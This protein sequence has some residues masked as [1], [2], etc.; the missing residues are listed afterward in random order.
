MNTYYRNDADK[1]EHATH[2]YAVVLSMPEF[3][4]IVFCHFSLRYS[5]ID[6]Y[7][8]WSFFML[9]FES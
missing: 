9:L 7:V 4:R 2:C 8:E 6:D 5:L 3:Y 1:A